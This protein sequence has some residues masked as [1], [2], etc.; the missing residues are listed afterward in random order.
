MKIIIF[1]IL[2]IYILS[3]Y[4]C[5]NVTKDINI[6]NKKKNKKRQS[7]N[8]ENIDNYLK[9]HIFLGGK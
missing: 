1:I 3:F 8:L 6:N 4:K 7:P 2:S 9:T 5:Y